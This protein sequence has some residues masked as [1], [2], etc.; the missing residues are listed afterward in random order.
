MTPDMAEC[1]RRIHRMEGYLEDAEPWMRPIVMESLVR[2]GV[3]EQV[4]VDEMDA[5][6]VERQKLSE[7]LR[8]PR[9]I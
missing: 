6:S 5:T 2:G 7:L 8:K 1:R 3:P 4:V 9:A